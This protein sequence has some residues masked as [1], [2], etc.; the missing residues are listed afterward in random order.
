MTHRP[1]VGIIGNGV[2]GA[3]ASARLA[4]KFEVTCFYRPSGSGSPMSTSQRNHA[5]IQS[6]LLYSE[7]D[8]VA[9]RMGP[10]GNDLLRRFRIDPPMHPGIFG[11]PQDRPDL[12]DPM[13]RMADRLGIAALVQQ[14]PTHVAKSRL[15]YLHRDDYSYYR[16]PDGP[17]DEGELLKRATDDA[18]TLGARFVPG[19]ARVVLDANLGIA[20]V[21][22]GDESL[23][24]DA[25]IMCAGR[26]TAEL[27]EQL[28]VKD[29]NIRSY[30]SALL[31]V[32]D[33][34]MSD[35][36]LFADRLSGLSVVQH[37]NVCVVGSR[38]RVE[39]GSMDDHSI[40]RDEQEEILNLLPLELRKRWEHAPLQWTGGIKTEGLM[41]NGRSTVE[42]IIAGPRRHGIANLIVSLPGKATLASYAIDEIQREITGLL[43]TLPTPAIRT[44]ELGYRGKASTLSAA[45][46]AMHFA[47]E[48]DGL[49]DER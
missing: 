49:N 32:E 15:G 40:G 14:L 16:V 44:S 8:K 21:E 3:V 46:T 10:S 45:D 24:P 28:G 13:R 4:A 20:A 17:F 1:K 30:R 23:E 26:G 47:P 9:F 36:G 27:L 18:A 2:L 41:S 38:G 7:D 37:G 6:G 5:W 35:C 34:P 19:K 29:L 43:G 12:V 33:H 31:R 11:Y 22:A 42:P 39:P 25:L 48:H